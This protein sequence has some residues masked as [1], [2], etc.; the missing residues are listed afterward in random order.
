MEGQTMANRSRK[1][2]YIEEVRRMYLDEKM[3]LSE[4]SAELP[5]SVQT[6]SR[7]LTEDG[8]QLEARPRNANAGRTAEQQAA[9]NAK[10]SATQQGRAE[11]GLIVGRPSGAREERICP[12]CTQ[13]FLA[14]ASS[15]KK[16]CSL[17]CARFVQAREKQQQVSEAWYES[18]ASTCAC[19]GKIPYEHRDTWKYCSVECRQTY[20]GKRQPNPENHVTFICLNCGSSVT[21]Y[22]GYGN[23]HLKYCSNECAHRH[24]KTRKFYA[25]EG[26]DIVFE[27]TWETLFW[28][29]CG[30]L[31]LPVERF[32]RERGIEWAQGF[33]YAPDF[34]LPTLGIAVEVKGLE[35]PDDVTRWATFRERTALAVVQRG[36]LDALRKTDDL[37]GLLKDF[38]DR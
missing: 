20:G 17:H 22:K 26:F 7:W 8:V 6:L 13:A 21:R 15:P 9:I 1:P 24:T 18:D 25:V 38:A 27:S 30:L 14:R 5:V 28:G 10:I 33:W 11:Q 31:K 36:E 23:G 19:G 3:S 35:D 32:D 29:L 4:I 16:C 2:Q 34:W 37:A 12:G